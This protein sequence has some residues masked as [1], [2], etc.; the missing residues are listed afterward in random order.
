MATSVVDEQGRVRIPE[1]VR[2]R[3]GLKAGDTIVWVPL[4]SVALVRK[5]GKVSVEEIRRRIDEL[6][7]KAPERFT[8]DETELP[9]A[10]SEAE[11]LREWALAKLGLRE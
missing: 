2:R 11:A 10:G 6:R 9:P 3:M 1:E 7:R 5:K 4:G 8:A